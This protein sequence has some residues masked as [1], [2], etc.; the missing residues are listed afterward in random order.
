MDLLILNGTSATGDILV[1]AGEDVEVRFDV[2]LDTGMILH[3]NDT[4]QLVQ[5]PAGPVIALRWRGNSD[6]GSVTL[7]VPIDVTVQ[8][9]VRYVS[10]DAVHPEN[11]RP[12]EVIARVAHPDDVGSIPLVSIAKATFTELT[13]RVAALEAMIDD[14]QNQ[15]N[16]N[17]GDISDLKDMDVDLQKQIDFHHNMRVVF[18]TSDTFDGKLDGTPG[19]NTL[20]QAAANGPQSIVPFGTYLA[21]ISDGGDSPGTT[22]ARSVFGYKLPDGSQIVANDYDDLVGGI[23]RNTISMD[24]NGNKHLDPTLL[25]WTGVLSDGFAAE[26][27]NCNGWTTDSNAGPQ[28]LNGKLTR[29]DSQWTDQAPASCDGLRRL[30]C[31]QQ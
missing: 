22:F 15:I 3:K 11:P 23:L 26:A 29:P 4:I 7:S 13:I 16:S 8:L 28:G 14:L 27:P 18:V 21:W 2:K 6:S 9:F 30:Y 1:V 31:F 24:E 19:A 5:S 25:V 17:D 12:S 20:C 10:K